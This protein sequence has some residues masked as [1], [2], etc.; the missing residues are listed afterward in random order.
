MKRFAA[1]IAFF[2]LTYVVSAQSADK[3]SQIIDSQEITYGQSAWLACSCAT[4]SGD[5]M[6]FEEAVSIAAKKGWIK[7]GFISD[8]TINLQELCGMFVKVSQ[9]KCGLLYRITK[10]DRY[11]YKELRANGTLDSSADPSMK[12]TGPNAVAILNSCI[13]KAGGGK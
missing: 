2:L 12:V 6:S 11:A 1:L 9:V 7:D 3:I 5:K 8:G 13:K 10:S 4:E